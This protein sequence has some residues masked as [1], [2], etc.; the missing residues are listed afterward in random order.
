MGYIWIINRGSDLWGLHIRSIRSIRT[1]PP[2]G[3]KRVLCGE[4]T[5][6]PFGTKHLSS[7]QI[8]TG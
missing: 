6:T 2:R 8:G 4:V 5:E 1:G 7:V 3:T